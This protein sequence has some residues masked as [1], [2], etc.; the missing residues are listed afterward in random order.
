MEDIKLKYVIFLLSNQ[1]EKDVNLVFNCIN[2]INQKLK[3]H[4]ISN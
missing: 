4:A 2:N 3:A 1:Y